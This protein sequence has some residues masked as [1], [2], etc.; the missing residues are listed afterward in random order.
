MV[1]KISK[2]LTLVWDNQFGLQNRGFQFR[3]FANAVRERNNSSFTQFAY[4]TQAELRWKTKYAWVKLLVKNSA[5]NRT[6]DLE[7]SLSLTSSQYQIQL[8]REKLKDYRQQTTQ[9]NWNS[10][11]TLKKRLSITHNFVGELIRYDTPSNNNYDDRDVLLYTADQDIKAKLKPNFTIGTQLGGVYRHIVYIFG[12]QS[13]ENYVQYVAK[14]NPYLEWNPKKVQLKVGYLQMSMYNVHDFVQ[15]TNNDR[16]TRMLSTDAHLNWKITSNLQQKVDF[17]YSR[18]NI[19]KLNWKDFTEIPIDTTFTHDWIYKLSYTYKSM[20]FHVGYHHFLQ[21]RRYESGYKSTSTGFSK[22]IFLRAN[23]F[24]TGPTVAIE[25]SISE[26]A[27]FSIEQWFQFYFTRYQYRE[28]TKIPTLVSFSESE[29]QQKSNLRL[30]PYFLV[31]FAW[32]W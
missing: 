24:Q 32:K 16:S 23:N 27:Q 30:V 12:Q 22:S 5:E 11:L 31:N 1:Y 18:R 19:G 6:F 7:N 29:L 4:L 20:L 3:P 2:R 14:M 26:K 8:D 13:Q 28:S 9:W 15:P 17:L 10:E 25:G 21:Q